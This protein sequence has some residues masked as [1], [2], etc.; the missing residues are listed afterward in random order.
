MQFF[1]NSSI[2]QFVLLFSFLFS[3]SMLFSQETYVLWQATEQ[4]ETI[5]CAVS[6]E[7]NRIFANIMVGEYSTNYEEL[8]TNYTNKLL[9]LN[10]KLQILQSAEINK[11]GNY[12]IIIY[13]VLEKTGNEI[14]VWGRSLSISTQDNQLV[15]IHIDTQLN[16]LDYEFYGDESLQ[17]YFYSGLQDNAGNYVFVGSTSLNGYDGQL[18]YLK[19]SP[20]GEQLAY[21]I[22]Q[23]IQVYRSKIIQ[24]NTGNYYLFNAFTLLEMD[25][26]FSIL[27]TYPYQD[28]LTVVPAGDIEVVDNNHFACTGVFMAPPIPG[29][30]SAIDM[31]YI[32]FN[33]VYE[34]LVEETIGTIDTTDFGKSIAV[35]GEDT[36]YISAEKNFSNNPVDDSWISVYK[37]HNQ[38]TP[39]VWNIGGDGQYTNGTLESL[40]HGGFVLGTQMWDFLNYPGEQK[41]RDVLL[42]TKNYGDTLV[43]MN[44]LNSNED[45]SIFPQ[46]AHDQL[47]IKQAY[48]KLSLSIYDAQGK[49]LLEKQIDNNTGIKID[50]LPVG[51]YFYEFKKNQKSVKSGKLLKK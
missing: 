48:G 27:E 17:E 20:T 7:P 24:A 43:G 25:E 26:D 16:V 49:L 47:Y 22:N 9:K 50:Q 15:I 45:L 31:G 19:V 18:V 12:E 41:Q 11:L 37:I 6:Y 13:G 42:F 40:N 3:F 5:R 36:L 33:E 2:R 10:Y 8:F 14:V 21:G 30:I 32:I 29:S 39:Q 23:D 35:S 51:M 28:T 46:P 44:P 34:P 38:D 1:L 4:D